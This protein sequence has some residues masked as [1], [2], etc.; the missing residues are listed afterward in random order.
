MAVYEGQRLKHY[1]L[2]VGAI[3]PKAAVFEEGREG[4]RIMYET[5]SLPDDG[6]LKDTP[7]NSTPPPEIHTARS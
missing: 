2:L 5:Y 3:G 4:F 7:N 6:C 1:V